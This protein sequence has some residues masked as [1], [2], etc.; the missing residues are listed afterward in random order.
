MTEFITIAKTDEQFWPLLTG[1]FSKTQFAQPVQNL[2]VNSPHETVTFKIIDKKS[3]TLFEALSAWYSLARNIFLVFP[4]VTGFAFFIFQMGSLDLF[5]V[6]SSFLG[7]QFF[8]MALTLYNDYR[9]YISGVDRVNGSGSKKPLM[10]G[11]IRAYQA[12]QLA[13]VFMV[14]SVVASSFCF[15]MKPSSLVFALV[16][17]LLGLSLTSSF[18]LKTMKSLSLVATFFL[19]GPLLISGF[20][21]LL[22]DKVSLS[23]I[24]LGGL[25]GLHALKY[26]YSKQ[27]RD[28]YFNSKAQLK[29]IP[30]ILGFE[31]AKLIYILLSIAHV[32]MLSGFAQESGLK[33]IWFLVIVALFFETYIN[34]FIFTAPSFLSSQISYA[35][36]LQKL[37]Y[38]MECGLL[39]FIFLSPLWLSLF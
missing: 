30:T 23:S 34:R 13:L 24:L 35:L 15:W 18:L 28:I 1:R 20:E 21:F 22:F 39:V 3:F 9:D 11:L 33:E 7:L 4:V 26:D 8:L 36:S 16:A 25:F 17:F 5:L 29:T 37:H 19:A 12:R 32:F 2:Y 14:L 38:T 10:T 27:V 6:L 31:R